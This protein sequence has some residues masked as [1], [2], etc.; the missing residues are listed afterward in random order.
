MSDPLQNLPASVYAASGG[1]DF[2]GGIHIRITG[3]GHS[4]PFTSGGIEAGVTPLYAYRELAHSNLEGRPFEVRQDDY[5]AV[6]LS[7]SSED[8]S[9]A[10]ITHEEQHDNHVGYVGYTTT[11][12]GVLVE[13]K[14]YHSS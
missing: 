8:P 3:H 11:A 2:V 6:V 14:L 13:L 12:R 1:M 9:G 10:G 4:Y 5:K 7:L